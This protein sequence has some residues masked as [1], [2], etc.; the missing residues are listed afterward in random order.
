MDRASENVVYDIT[1]EGAHDNFMSS[2][3]H[4]A[5]ILNP[6]FDAIGIGVVET[7]GVL[8][9]TEDFA[10]RLVD[11]S[12]EQAARVAAAAFS[13]LRRSTGADELT[14]ISTPR[15]HQIVKSIAQREVP[16]GAPGLALAGAR[17]SASYATTNPSRLP[18]S[19]AQL[20]A[21]RGLTHYS[22]A[23][24]YARSPK[25]PGGLYWVTIVL[26][27]SPELR[28]AASSSLQP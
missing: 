4:R 22:V 15:L 10:H 11:V 1:A 3:P 6:A 20:A 21:L 8:Y 23:A 18:P 24:C 12:D 25:Y 9:I 14:L 17:F 2:A 19:I 13:N 27:H 7:D 28:A 26:F 5:N 16:E